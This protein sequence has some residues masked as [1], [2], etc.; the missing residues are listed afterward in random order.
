MRRLK[1]LGYRIS[2][3]VIGWLVKP[4]LA[5]AEAELQLAAPTAEE[6]PDTNKFIYVMDTR[7]LSDLIVVDLVCERLEMPGP[8]EPIEYSGHTEERR[9]FFLNR[10]AG[11]WFRR[12]TMQTY[13]KRMV[14]ILGNADESCEASLL[15][16]AVFY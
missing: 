13:S 3:R 1:A 6:T 5:G 11:G 7:S 4:Q 16:V 10:S 12:D 2:R 15:P 9:F 14:R 8:L